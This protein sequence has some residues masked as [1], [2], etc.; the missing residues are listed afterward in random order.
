MPHGP[1]RTKVCVKCSRV[2]ALGEFTRDATNVDGLRDTCRACWAPFNAHINGVSKIAYALAG[3]PSQ[4]YR[5]PRVTRLNLR[6]H[7]KRLFDAGK[8]YVTATRRVDVVDG[9]VYVITNPAWPDYVKIGS[10]INPSNRLR[11]YQTYCPTRSYTLEHAVYARDR[12][13]AEADV[14][15]VFEDYRVAGEWF[16]V[17]VDEAREVLNAVAS[18]LHFFTE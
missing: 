1:T 5:L 12:R 13:A 9:F 18:P 11:D 2:L 8:D 10:A 7:A 17:S 14:H 15:W 16:R 3:G 6:A 4:F